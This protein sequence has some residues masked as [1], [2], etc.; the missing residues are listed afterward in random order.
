VEI[1]RLQ[2]E[3]DDFKMEAAAQQEDTKAVLEKA[4]EKISELKRELRI[5]K[6]SKDERGTRPKSF[7]GLASTETR[8]PSADDKPDI[9]V[10][11]R[12]LARLTNSASP[13]AERQI[14]PSSNLA[15]ELDAKRVRVTQAS[16]A[17]RERFLG[18]PDDLKLGLKTD[19]APRNLLTDRV[20]L[21]RPKWQPYIPRSPRNRAY[22]RDVGRCNGSLDLDVADATPKVGQ[23]DLDQDDDDQPQ[24]D[25]L[26]ERFKH[27]GLPDTNGS[28]ILAGNTSRCTLPPDR[29]A[30]ALARIE[31]RK[32]ERRQAIAGT[33]KALDKE[34]VRPTATAARD[35]SSW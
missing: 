27:L 30:A 34:N 7:H 28:S 35:H 5:L 14:K 23:V 19:D 24:L 16:R 3:F 18:E 11:L 8:K 12:D 26:K 21:E 32:A 9:H 33:L 10:D 2:Q 17:L 13:P 1:K 6:A 20:N 22:L 15:S 29:R 4:T 31:Q 25:M